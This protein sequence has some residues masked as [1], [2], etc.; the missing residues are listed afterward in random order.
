VLAAEIYTDVS[1]KQLRAKNAELNRLNQTLQVREAALAVEGVKASRALASANEFNARVIES[2]TSGVIVFSADTLIITLYSQRMEA[3][4]GVP[5]EEALGR[6]GREAFARV[7]GIDHGAII[8]TVRSTGSFPL[9]KIQMVNARDQKRVVFLRAQRMYDAQGVVE[10]TVMV[11]DDVSERELLVDSFSRY[12]SRDLITRLLLRAEPLGLEGEKRTCT[13]LF[14]DIRGFTGIA[15]RL[16]PEELHR[17]LNDFLHIMVES[18]IESGGFIDKFVG[19]KVMA[20]FTGERSVERSAL[21]AVEAARTILVRIAQQNA[22]RAAQGQ[23]PIEVGIGINTG[24][25]VVG[26]VGSEARMD[27]TA[28]GDVVNVADRLQSLAKGGQVLVGG[29][30]ADAVRGQVELVD[31]GAQL[32]KG[33]T[34]PVTVFEVAGMLREGPSYP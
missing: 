25:V 9:T 29:A 31:L 2:L 12:V 5:A 22:G 7:K 15:E 1:A 17:L 26:N 23:L 19:D 24:P 21:A 20:L 10:G 34:S 28:I 16:P 4:T 8:Q 27:F 11:V 14:A 30:T 32:V 13:V 3:I 6:E 33:R 18:I